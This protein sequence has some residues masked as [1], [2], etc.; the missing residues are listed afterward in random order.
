MCCTSGL[1]TGNHRQTA[2]E[3]IARGRVTRQLEWREEAALSKR[4]REPA[5]QYAVLDSSGVEPS[6]KFKAKPRGRGYEPIRVRGSE[7]GGSIGLCG[8]PTE[9]VNRTGSSLAAAQP[10]RLMAPCSCIQPLSPNINHFFHKTQWPAHSSDSP[11][12]LPSSP[13]T[14]LSG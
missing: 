11:L 5:G 1:L 6:R 10:L 9:R 14:S 12:Y 2:K 4:Y 13:A 3:G 7:V 8:F